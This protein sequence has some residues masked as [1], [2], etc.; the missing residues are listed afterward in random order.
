MYLGGAE[1]DARHV[2]PEKSYVH[3][4]I[5]QGPALARIAKYVFF[6]LAYLLNSALCGCLIIL[7]NASRNME[8]RAKLVVEWVEQNLPPLSWQIIVMQNMKIFLKHKVSPSKFTD[9]TLLHVE[10]VESINNS[11]RERYQ[12]E[13]PVTIKR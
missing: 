9:N 7:E 6:N 1:T 13:L 8:V 11:I 3:S 2:V 4:Q 10:I 5:L 12:K